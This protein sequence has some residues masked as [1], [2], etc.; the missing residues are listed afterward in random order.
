MIMQNSDFAGLMVDRYMESPSYHA[1]Y[2]IIVINENEEAFYFDGYTSNAYFIRVSEDSLNEFRNC[3]SV[4]EG[5]IKFTVIQHDYKSDL[6]HQ[7]LQA[8]C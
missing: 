1:K 2:T 5:M 7:A 8:M 4:N 6:I 3:L